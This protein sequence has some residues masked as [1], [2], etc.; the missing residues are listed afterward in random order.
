MYIISGCLLGVN[1]NY[2]GGNNRCEWV[3]DFAAK[4]SH[5]AVCPETAGG[6]LVP[7]P[8]AEIKD[9]RVMNNLGEDV[10]EIYE[11]GAMNTFNVAA[12]EAVL[13]EEPIEG[14]ILKSNSPSCG[15]G[16]IYDGTFSGKLI[17]GDGVLTD[18]LKN[19]GIKVMTEKDSP[20][21]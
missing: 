1:C 15:C 5:L 11:R 16:T 8:P 9:G 19:H 20:I 14:A 6:L 17:D 18:V 10:T 7:R 12:T 21:E 13:R 2:K 4:H 3:C